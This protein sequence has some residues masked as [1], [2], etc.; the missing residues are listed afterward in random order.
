M[1]CSMTGFGEAEREADGRVYHV[2]IRSVNNRYLKTIVRLPEEFSFLEPRLERLVRE[3][4]TRGSV[5]VRLSQRDLS[6]Q[7]AQEVNVAAARRYVDRLRAACGSQENVVVDLG[8]LALLP[9]VCQPAEMSDAQRDACAAQIEQVAQEALER[10]VAMRQ[11]EGRAVAE[12]LKAHCA[13]L[14]EQIDAIRALAPRVVQE[15][16]DRLMQRVQE[17]LAGSNVP[18][19]QE[20]LLREVS[21]YAERSDVSEELSRLASHLEQ[22]E[23]AMRGDEPAGRKLDFIAQE[24]LRETNTIGSKAGDVE[25]A[26]RVIEMKAAIDRIKEQ[27]QNVE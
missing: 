4:L 14:R 20:D 5:T 8:T 9:G 6:A 11:A 26:K 18:L 24:M 15:Y 21:V 12:D 19:A 2:E 1:I 10:L 13:V 23:A 22:F 16:R 17:L 3:R 27:V 7:A 25:I